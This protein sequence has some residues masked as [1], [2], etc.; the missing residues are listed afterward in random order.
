MGLGINI[1]IGNNLVMI[2]I[3]TYFDTYFP[4]TNCISR[5][6]ISVWIKTDEEAGIDVEVH[7]TRAASYSYVRQNNT[8]FMI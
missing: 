2:P 7:S 8:A 1:K 3:I 4:Y 6:T 5:N